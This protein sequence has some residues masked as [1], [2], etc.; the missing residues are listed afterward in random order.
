MAVHESSFIETST[1]ERPWSYFSNQ[2][3]NAWHW[4]VSEV[5]DLCVK[6]CA[7]CLCCVTVLI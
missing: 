5:V 4:I 1:I 6:W 7:V 3:D 2:N